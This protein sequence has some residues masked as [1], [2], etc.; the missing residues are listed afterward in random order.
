MTGLYTT[1]LSALGIKD[2]WPDPESQKMLLDVIKEVKKGNTGES[3]YSRYVKVCDNLKKK[4]TK[5]AIIACTEL[6]ALQSDLPIETVDAAHVL[7]EEII[8]IAKRN[9]PSLC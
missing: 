3:V 5:T 8:R 6:S 2:I 1:K 9:E 7:A 4:G